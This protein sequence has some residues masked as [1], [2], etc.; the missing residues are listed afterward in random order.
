MMNHF[1]T[2]LK[3]LLAGRMELEMSHDRDHRPTWTLGAVS[4]RFRRSELRFGSLET[5][6]DGIAFAVCSPTLPFGAN[7]RSDGPILVRTL[8][9]KFWV[10]SG[11]HGPD[12]I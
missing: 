7:Q 5:R 6:M 8:W 12:A 1:H 2:D 10:N 3:T 4:S 11:G 9:D